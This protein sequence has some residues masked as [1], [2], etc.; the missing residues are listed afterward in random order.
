MICGLV[1]PSQGRFR[2]A[3]ESASADVLHRNADQRR[4]LQ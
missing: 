2:I 4:R 1:Q 3:G